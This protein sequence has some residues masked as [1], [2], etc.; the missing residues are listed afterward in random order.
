MLP[1][2]MIR[3]RSTPRHSFYSRFNPRR[4]GIFLR[5]HAGNAANPFRSRGYL[6]TCGH[7][8]GGGLPSFSV[9]S[10]PSAL[11]STRSSTSLDPFDTRHRPLVYPACPVY[12]D[13]RRELRRVPIP[14]RI[15]TS[16]KSARNPFRM[17]SSKT[18]HLKLF[19]MNSYEKRGRGLI[20]AGG[21]ARRGGATVP[22][23]TLSVTFSSNFFFIFSSIAFTCG[24]ASA[25]IS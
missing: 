13:S 6:I 18:K 17:S 21:Y 2:H 19:R 4:S 3:R 23:K 10:V 9:N 24:T 15:R 20:A 8:G 5:V 11:R 16:V 7:P 1:S 14:F 25:T 12:P 22:P